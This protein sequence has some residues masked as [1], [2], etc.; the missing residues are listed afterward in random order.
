MKSTV[1]LSLG[2]ALMSMGCGVTVY[3]PDRG[4]HGN[5]GSGSYAYVN[6]YV[7]LPSSVAECIAPS[8]DGYFSPALSRYDDYLY[9]SSTPYDPYNLP[10]FVRSDFNGDGFDDFAFL[11]SSQEWTNGNWY[12][13]TKLIVALSTPS[14]YEIGAD[15]ILGTVTGSSNTPIEEYWSIY[16][17]PAGIHSMTTWHNGVKMTKTVTVDED[18]FYLASLDPNEEALFYAT[19]SD[20]YETNALAK[21]LAKKTALGKTSATAQPRMITFAKNVTGRTKAIQ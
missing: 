14:G 2:I 11:F 17:V 8:A 16:L 7:S 21:T 19:G 1:L 4:S 9:P 12:L 15:E 6:T 20:I 5:G 10:C 3:G 18:A 13:T